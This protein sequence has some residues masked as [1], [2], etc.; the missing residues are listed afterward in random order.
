MT[1]EP[2][3]SSFRKALAT[4]AVFLAGFLAGA[5]CAVVFLTKRNVSDEVSEDLWADKAKERIRAESGP[6]PGH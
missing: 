5:A 4:G 3:E 2:D 6:G 1:R